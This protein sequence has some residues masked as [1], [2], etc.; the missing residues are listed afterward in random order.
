MCLLKEIFSHFVSK[1][2]GHI[3]RYKHGT[4]I[5]E[6][7]LWIEELNCLSHH[8]TADFPYIRILGGE[9]EGMLFQ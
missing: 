9:G 4:L 2:V 6:T 5:W 1:N 3:H 8:L 7:V